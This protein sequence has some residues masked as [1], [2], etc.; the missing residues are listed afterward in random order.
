MSKIEDL[1]ADILEFR[2]ER[3]WKQF[4]SPKNLA[5]SISV[6]AS[7]LLE[8]F[9]WG[10]SASKDEISDEIADVFIYLILLCHDLDIDLLKS[11]RLKMQKNRQK[12]PVFLAKGKSAK[13]MK[14]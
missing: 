6:E 12:Y 9:Q 13:W 10:E 4:H 3:D 1:L 8:L 11:A 2:K 7:E 5:I 14:L